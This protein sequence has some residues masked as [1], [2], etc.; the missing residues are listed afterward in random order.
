[1][2]NVGLFLLDPCFAHGQHYVGV[3]R[4][5]STEGLTIVFQQHD[6]GSYSTRNV[7]YREAVYAQSERT[8]AR[9]E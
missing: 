4:A 1:M 5:T 3:S 2:K 7:V 6:N 8:Y 9:E